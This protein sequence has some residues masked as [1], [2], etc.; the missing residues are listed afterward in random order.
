[1]PYTVNGIGT[2]YYGRRNAHTVRDVCEHCGS[3]TDVTSYDVTNY[4]VFFYIPLI[5]LGKKRVFDDCAVCRKHRVLSLKEWNKAKDE[6]ISAITAKLRE[7]PDNI[8]TVKE[9]L[10]IAAAYQDEPLFLRLAESLAEH[11]TEDAELQALLGHCYAF[12]SHPDRAEQAFLRSLK[13]KRDEAVEEQLAIQLLK[14]SRPEQAEPLLNHILENTDQTKVLYIIFLIEGYQSRGEH[15]KAID[16]FDRMSEAFPDVGADKDLQKMR[17][18]SEKRLASSKPIKPQWLGDSK[19]A[20]EEGG[21]SAKL[22]AMIGPLIAAAVLA[23]Y[24]M[25]SL[26]QGRNRKV[27]VVNGLHK[28]YAV[29]IGDRTVSLPAQGR[30]EITIAEGDVP[31]SAADAVPI[32]NNTVS[33][34]TSFFVRP[35]LS[36]TFVL[37]PDC[38]AIISQEKEAY[39]QKHLAMNAPEAGVQYFVGKPVY[40]FSGIDYEFEP[41]PNQ[42]KMSKGSGV[43]YRERVSVERFDWKNPIR[44]FGMV[45]GAGPDALH[46]WLER[47]VRLDPDN[48]LALSFLSRVAKDQQAFLELVR[49]RLGDRPVRV[50]WHRV[51][52]S[53]I[54]EHQPDYDLAAEYAKLLEKEPDNAQLMYLNGRIAVKS[55]DRLELVTKAASASPPSAYAANALAYHH[56]GMGD[57]EQAAQWIKKALVFDP[58]NMQFEQLRRSIEQA[59]GRYDASIAWTRQ[60]ADAS[61]G[62]PLSMTGLARL[63]YLRDG[64]AK[65]NELINKYRQKIIGMGAGAQADKV[66]SLPMSA[67][68]YC[69]GDRDAFVK[70]YAQGQEMLGDEFTLPFVKGEYAQAAHHIDPDSDGAAY[71]HLLIYLAARQSDDQQT[72]KQQLD[73]AVKALSSKSPDERMI[74]DALKEPAKAEPEELLNVALDLWRKKIVLAALGARNPEWQDDFWPLAQK[75]NFER[76]MPYLFLNDLFAGKSR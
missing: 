70:Q 37:N 62:D 30:K 17:M 34:K 31:V 63:T 42:I 13:I 22:A 44:A 58:E 23:V 24:C 21:K 54:E 57:F 73:L 16:V 59:M 43:V 35:F 10:Q 71:N 75:L 56:L 67:V 9:A 3:F 27:Y 14:Q 25:A 18:A 50:D 6:S 26:N 29:K 39:G 72:A 40:E 55:A 61:P 2:W 52:Q 47:L 51:Y 7:D 53:A 36:R 46:D 33:V 41:F 5:P 32:P 19:K 38:T 12:F 66:C 15:Q 69:K 76:T 64:E 48:S 45:S 60:A 4:F 20:Y 49:S 28:P 68:S 8:E 65:A 11:E 74:A 1:M